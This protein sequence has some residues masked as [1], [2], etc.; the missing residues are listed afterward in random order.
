MDAVRCTCVTGLC[1]CEQESHS[2][3]G[4]GQSGRHVADDG[5]GQPS[6]LIRSIQGSRR[7]ETED[8]LNSILGRAAQFHTQRSVQRNQWRTQG[9]YQ[10]CRKHSKVFFKFLVAENEISLLKVSRVL[11]NFHEISHCCR[12]VEMW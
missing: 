8:H 12:F 4:V 9:D 1:G 11:R 7:Q 3:A 2:G 10:R 5:S 6:R